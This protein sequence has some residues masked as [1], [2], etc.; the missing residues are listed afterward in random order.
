MS[1]RDRGWAHF[2]H[3]AD[4][5]IEGRGESLAQAF[6]Q[7]AVAMTAV[8]TEPAGV[9]PVAR[10]PVRVEETDPELLLVSWLDAV[11][12]E[13]ATRRMLFGRF[14]VQIDGLGVEADLWGEPVDPARHEP[15]VEVKGVT[16]A[17]LSVREVDGLWI[18]RV[19]VDV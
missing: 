12:F 1:E 9:R 2:E 3:E 19:V 14:E 17:E 10:V 4:V 7:A 8:I 13:M 15:V 5:G 6:A 11:V 16:L 18:A